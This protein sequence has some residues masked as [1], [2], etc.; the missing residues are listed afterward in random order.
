MLQFKLQSK[1]IAQEFIWHS[2]TD[3]QYCGTVKELS[4]FVV[5]PRWNLRPVGFRA[6]LM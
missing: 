1:W 2:A 5:P 4:Y 6:L 3:S